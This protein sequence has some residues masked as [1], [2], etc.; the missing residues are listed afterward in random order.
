MPRI[1][2]DIIFIPRNRIPRPAITIPRLFFFSSFENIIRQTPAIAI[3][4]ATSE[5]PMDIRIPVI[6]VPILAPMITPTVFSKAIRP[7]FTKPTSI[8][9]VADDD[10]II[11]VIRAPTRTPLKVLEVS[12]SR[13]CFI[14]SPATASRPSLIICIP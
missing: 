5:I 7:E 13:I 6:V 11:A 12:F 8:T 3:S 14:L 10:W 2:S 1:A 9:V 4:G